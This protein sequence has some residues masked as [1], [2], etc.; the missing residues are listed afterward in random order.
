MRRMKCNCGSVHFK[1][2]PK[3]RMA[4]CSSCS[5][6]YS[7]WEKEGGWKEFKITKIQRLVEICS[8]ST[9]LSPGAIKYIDWIDAKLRHPKREKYLKGLENLANIAMEEPISLK[10][11]QGLSI[12]KR[13][14]YRWKTEIITLLDHGIIEFGKN[15]HKGKLRGKNIAKIFHTDLKRIG[16]KTK[17]SFKGMKGIV[18]KEG[19]I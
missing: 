1:I 4:Q 13:I 9:I 3:D 17:L 2:N 5:Q 19:S 8:E 12:E 10:K 11:M 16:I 14:R 15:E 7:W 18:E 6:R